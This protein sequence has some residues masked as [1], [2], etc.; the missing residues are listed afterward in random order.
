MTDSAF[1]SPR[2]VDSVSLTSNSSA[3]ARSPN[4]CPPASSGSLMRRCAWRLGHLLLDFG[5]SWPLGPQIKLE[6]RASLV[7]RPMHQCSEPSAD[8]HR[9]PP[10][11]LAIVHSN[12]GAVV[13]IIHIFGCVRVTIGR[14]WCLGLRQRSRK[15]KIQRFSW[16]RSVGE[17]QCRFQKSIHWRP[18]ACRLPRFR[19]APRSKSKSARSIGSWLAVTPTSA[20]PSVAESLAASA[21][22]APATAATCSN[23]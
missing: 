13:S 10:A 11:T 22:A 23:L 7:D 17:R 19:P 2:M 6:A 5:L 14:R 12:L 8:E 21:L 16:R 20:L 1:D 15:I 3:V 18:A 4:R 9:D